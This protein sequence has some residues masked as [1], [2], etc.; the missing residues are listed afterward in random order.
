VCFSARARGGEGGVVA[1]AAVPRFQACFV[2]RR[3]SGDF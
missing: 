2:D 3:L 1:A